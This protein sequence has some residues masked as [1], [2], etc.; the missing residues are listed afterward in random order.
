MGRTAEQMGGS[1]KKYA[2]QE[3][4]FSIM[5]QNGKQISDE[6]IRKIVDPLLEINDFLP[7]NSLK[8]ERTALEMTLEKAENFADKMLNIQKDA[9]VSGCRG[10]CTGLC[11]LACASTCMGC[12]SCSGNCSTTCGKQCSDGCSG[13]CGG[14][15]GGC[16]NGCTHTC[17]AGCTTSIKA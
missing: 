13:G 10:N 16:S 17:G 3:Y 1:L 9:K 15:T 11:E 5:P 4:D 12:A 6:H 14:C 8:K 7:D 2:S